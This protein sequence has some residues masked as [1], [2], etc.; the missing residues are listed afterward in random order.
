MPE[1]DT[2]FVADGNPNVGMTGENY[3]KS[4]DIKEPDNDLSIHLA[5]V[6]QSAQ[7]ARDF[8][9]NKQWNLLWR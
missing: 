5:T 2:Q 8:I 9:Q 1:L 4:G 6:V 7:A 3:N